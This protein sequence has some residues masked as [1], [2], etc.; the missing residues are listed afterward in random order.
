MNQQLLKG[1]NSIESLQETGG[2]FPTQVAKSRHSSLV[3][4]KKYRVLFL[5]AGV[6]VTLVVCA[7]VVTAVA[8]SQLLSAESE[9]LD[10]GMTGDPLIE[11]AT[12]EQQLKQVILLCGTCSS[13][14]Q[15]L[16][17]DLMQA[18]RIVL[19]MHTVCSYVN[20]ETHVDHFQ[21]VSVVVLSFV[22]FSN[23]SNFVL[24]AYSGS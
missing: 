24:F 14:V 12:N 9:K 6:L 15:E 13:S 19:C 10:K 3:V 5:I 4:S 17:R 16:Q 11:L 8:V 7:A 23:H 1:V 2:Y 21:Q 18:H 22:T 20:I